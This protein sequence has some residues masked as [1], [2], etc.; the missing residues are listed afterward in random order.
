MEI[1]IT[2]NGRKGQFEAYEGDAR[3]GVMAF[4]WEGASRFSILHTKVFPEYNGRGV[5][6]ALL[7]FAADY[8]R[9]HGKQVKAVCAFVQA[10]FAKSDAYDDI[11]V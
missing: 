3:M 7:D 4:T 6:K 8:A 10:Q 5:A 2:D 11:K 9:E 1:K